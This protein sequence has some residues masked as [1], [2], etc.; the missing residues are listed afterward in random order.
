[1]DNFEGA[2]DVKQD[3]SKPGSDDESSPGGEVAKQGG[4]ASCTSHLP[5]TRCVGA[6]RARSLQ[7]L[8]D[9]EMSCRRS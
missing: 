6:I 1:M 8:H 9:F 3:A 4:L 7:A 5:A 2:V